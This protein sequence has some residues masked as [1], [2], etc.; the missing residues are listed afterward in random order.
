MSLVLICCAL[1]TQGS[2]GIVDWKS[3]SEIESMI[4]SGHK[5]R[6]LVCCFAD[7]DPL[8]YKHYDWLKRSGRSL[9]VRERL[10]AC[11]VDLRELQGRSLGVFQKLFP[12]IP[13]GTSGVAI[14]D[15]NSDEVRW[16][17]QFE[18]IQSIGESENVSATD[19]VE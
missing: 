2:N 16:F 13:S 18:N 12:K 7:W 14:V 5:P 9:L 3:L 1:M 10:T 8:T 19:S 11:R 15:F 4:E 6:V 17:D